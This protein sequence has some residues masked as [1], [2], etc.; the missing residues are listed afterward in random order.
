[1][2]EAAG[3]TVDFFR[4]GT[5]QAYKAEFAEFVNAIS[6]TATQPSASPMAANAGPGRGCQQECAYRYGRQRRRSLTPIESTP[7]S[8]RRPSSDFG[9]ATIPTA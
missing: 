1:M 4:S 6:R 8:G 3:P 5:P 9:G 2:T 7:Q